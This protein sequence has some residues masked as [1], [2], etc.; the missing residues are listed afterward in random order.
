MQFN[1]LQR[2]LERIYQVEIS[3]NVDDFLIS[4]Q[5]LALFLS[6]LSGA[7]AS[8]E[9]L[10][11]REDG[12][13]LD[14][15]LYVDLSVVKRLAADDPTSRLHAGNIGD[16][17]TV[18]EGVSHFLY[19]LW[20]ARFGREI[21][22]LELELQAEVDKYITLSLLLEQQDR[23]SVPSTLVSHLFNEQVFDIRLDPVRRKR[24]QEAN[25]YARKFCLTLETRYPKIHRSRGLINELRR[26]YRL[27]RW[28]KIKHIAAAQ[29]P[30]F[31]HFKY[32]H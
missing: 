10:F 24:Y 19:L 13:N 20:N 25:Y 6:G 7:P 27:T 28:Q 2:Q 11:I 21:S 31:R 23:G 3:H 15:S 14:V 18:L 4:D 9:Q 16:F 17:C 32:R 1:H 29:G 8:S 22:A 26:F 12:D 5:K 30:H